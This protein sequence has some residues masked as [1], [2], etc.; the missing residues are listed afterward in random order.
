[1]LRDLDWRALV[2]RVAAATRASLSP[3]QR[4]RLLNESSEEAR[5][6]LRHPA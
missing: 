3:E 1:V 4:R 5:E 6:R 2:D